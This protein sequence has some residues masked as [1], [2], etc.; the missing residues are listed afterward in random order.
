MER[1]QLLRKRHLTREGEAR[2]VAAIGRAEAGNRGEVRVH[3]ESRY[4]GDGP[5]GR[6]AALFVELGMDATRDGTGVLL[7]VA[8]DDRKAAVFAGPGV[9]GAG[10]AGFWEGVVGEVAAGFARGDRASGLVRAVERVGELLRVACPGEDA[11]G[12]E[13]PNTVSM[14]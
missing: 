2:V 13:L 10:E 6:A 12:N 1:W 8:V 11:A 7:Y 3:L 14:G 4:P 9:H 5:L